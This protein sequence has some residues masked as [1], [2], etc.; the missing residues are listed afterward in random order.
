MTNAEDPTPMDDPHASIHESHDEPATVRP[1]AVTLADWQALRT[2]TPESVA[3]LSA[4][5]R[6][7]SSK[8]RLPRPSDRMSL[9]LEATPEEAA[10]AGPSFDLPDVPLTRTN[11]TVEFSADD[12]PPASAA[13]FEL[14]DVDFDSSDDSW[15]KGEKS[16]VGES[17]EP[18]E[19]PIRNHARLG[20]LVDRLEGSGTKHRCT[21]PPNSRPP[22]ITNIRPARSTKITGRA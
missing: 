21:S 15:L 14:A 2:S 12:L 3:D 10:V 11:A 18:A 1:S 4:R 13:D 8:S 17:A 7:R 16:L 19:M 22:T 6:R 5:L 20:S 9:K